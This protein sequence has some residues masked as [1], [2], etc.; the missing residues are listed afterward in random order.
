LGASLDQYAEYGGFIHDSGQHL[1][2]LINDIL[3][4]A[5][6]EAGRFTLR[7]DELDLVRLMEDAAQMMQVKADSGGLQLVI[8]TAPDFPNLYGDERALRQTVVNLLSNA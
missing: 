8:H 3:D 1:L 2:G 4:L 7:E 5:K 6:I